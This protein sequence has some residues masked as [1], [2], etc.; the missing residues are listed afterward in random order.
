[1]KK[2][3]LFTPALLLWAGLM[4]M[5][6]QAPVIQSVTPAATT[7]EQYG[8]FEVA[9]DLSATFQNPY[10]YDEIVVSAT[11]TAPD[12]VQETVDG[13]Y[14]QNF[15]FTNLTTGAISPGTSG[16]KV[17]FAP[18]KPGQWSYVVRVQTQAGADSAPSANFICTQPQTPGNSGFV[19]MDQSN[20][21]KFDNGFQYIPIGENIAW[22]QNNPY[23]N[24]TNWLTKLAA[25][26]GNFYRLWM[27]HWGLGLEWTGGGYQGLR[28]YRQN[29]SFYLDWLF[30][31]SAQKGV[32]AMFCQNH[33]GQ[34]SSQVNPNWAESPYNS[35]NGGPCAQTSDFFTLP[36]AK[37][38]IKNRNRYVVA[39]WGYSR[40]IMSWELFNEV[41]W[42]DNFEQHTQA[43]ADWHEDMAAQF[44]SLDVRRRLV[45]TSYAHED[46]GAETWVL[47]DIDFTQ[48]HHYLDVSNLERTLASANRSYL[49]QFDRP[50][51][52][53]EF[54]LGGS[55]SGLATQDPN[56]IHIHNSVF[57]GFYGGGMG[58]GMSWW[59]DSYIDP[60]NLY[61]HFKGLSESVKQTE[62]NLLDFRPATGVSVQGAS[63]DLVL[64]P[65]LGWGGLADTVFNIDAF[66]T[67]TPSNAKLAQYLY[68][69]TWNT[70]YRRPP[71][72]YL[73]LASPTQ[74]SVRTGGST[75]NS[76]RIVI[77]IDGVVALDQAAAVNRTYT[78]TLPAGQHRVTVD[79]TGT[80]WIAMAS[81][82]F[83][84]IGSEVDAYV[85]TS[86]DS[87]NVSGW[88]LNSRYNHQYVRANGVPAA[89]STAS[90]R[91][92]GVKSGAYQVK[93]FNCLT[94]ALVS[95]APVAAVN[96][97]LVLAVP[98]LT[99]DLTFV[100]DSRAAAVDPVLE[101]ALSAYPNP[102][103]GESVTLGFELEKA[104]PVTLSLLDA[105]G[106]VVWE[107]EMP[108][109]PGAQQLEIPV[110]G[111]LPSSIYWI[112][113]AASDRAAAK[114]LSVIR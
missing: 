85:L 96:D 81:Y 12:G 75:G 113:V 59:W 29:N 14:M 19:R 108:L 18:D 31:F 53:G 38:H 50:T 4:Q 56:G 3:Y 34:V 99:W 88:V 68:G 102:V 91:V 51:L 109:L 76:P 105:G 25:N 111:D 80:D 114:A 110:A 97:T 35:A 23:T 70:E 43:I 8:K 98:S 63:G 83:Q 49:D 84:N 22:Q 87:A 9:L 10:D 11:F 26:G 52:V 73:N 74:F 58:S 55:A 78:V 37:N 86:A 72:F 65:S 67:L 79:N 66:G 57:G 94:G 62:W 40:A 21:L 106:R 104:S 16:F 44:K 71:V 92:G 89:I 64:T 101:L 95:S 107:Q 7:V 48:T 2:A 39:R 20:Y 112:R 5:N 61:Y 33:H 28:Q 13:F 36:A 27:C 24:Y 42:T 103:R 47:P 32:Y 90:V 45:T 46:Q 15:T 60:R 82:T 6:A 93:W 1:M 69:S 41:N 30:D 17:R 77:T 54:G 100:V